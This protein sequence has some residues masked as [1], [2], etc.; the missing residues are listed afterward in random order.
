MDRADVCAC[1]HSGLGSLYNYEI[2]HMEA[3]QHFEDPHRYMRCGR[4]AERP[5]SNI[6]TMWVH[7]YPRSV[8]PHVVALADV[9]AR[10]CMNGKQ[11]VV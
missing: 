4:S 3:S 2:V 9:D 1:P 10:G 7:E 5:G 8:T 11:T 6:N